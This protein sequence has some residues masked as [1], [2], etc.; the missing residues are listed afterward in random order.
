MSMSHFQI[1]IC[2]E[3]NCKKKII[4]SL[5]EEQMAKSVH[6][7]LTASLAGQM[8]VDPLNRSF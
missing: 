6:Q 1:E 5:R 8:V 7:Q 4:H 3:L 2:E